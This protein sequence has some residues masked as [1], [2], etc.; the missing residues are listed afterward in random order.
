MDDDLI[1][2]STDY[3]DDLPE[4][5][6]VSREEWKNVRYRWNSEKECVEE[7]VIGTFSQ[8]PLKL[9]WAITVHKS[10]ELT[11]E[12]VVADL[13]NSFT[14]GQVYVALSR[15]TS[16]KN[17]VFTSLITPNCI[18]VDRRVQDFITYLES[19]E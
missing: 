16:L 18:K 11:F 17:L 7:E 13:G 9:A 19:R 14:A 5:I 15:C 2:V 12:R 6:A 3:D 10:Q 1:W 8:F 4:D